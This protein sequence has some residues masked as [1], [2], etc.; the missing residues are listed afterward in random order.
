MT[1]TEI[2]LPAAVVA[3]KRAI[4]QI[5]TG[6]RGFIVGAAK[7]RRY[8]ITAAHCLPQFPEPHLANSANELSYQDI[9]SALGKPE[10]KIWAELVEFNSASDF[11]V[12]GAPDDQA[13]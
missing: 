7:D 13:L 12:L 5:G 3:A 6:G 9:L 8:I 4:I 10:R 11:A 1:K 2:E